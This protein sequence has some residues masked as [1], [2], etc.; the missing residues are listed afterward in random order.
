MSGL[1]PDAFRLAARKLSTT[2]FWLFEMVG[3]VRR[4]V[5]ASIRSCVAIITAIASATTEGGSTATFS[6]CSAALSGGKL[7][8]LTTE[9]ASARRCSSV[10]SSPSRQPRIASGISYL[11]VEGQR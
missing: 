10:I 11:G 8:A 5:S 6:Y 2:R 9:S 1:S 3:K 7:N 4:K